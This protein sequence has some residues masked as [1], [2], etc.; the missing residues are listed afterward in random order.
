MGTENVKVTASN[1]YF[2]SSLPQRACVLELVYVTRSKWRRREL[3][4]LVKVDDTA[5]MTFALN[6]KYQ[7]TMSAQRLKIVKQAM[8]GQREN[9]RRIATPVK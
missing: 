3:L 7:F 1:M 9:A 5:K 2:A 6:F 4:M 8:D